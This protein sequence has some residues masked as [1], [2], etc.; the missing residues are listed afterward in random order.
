MSHSQQLGTEMHYGSEL[1]D[2]LALI[3]HFPMSSEVSEQMSER[4]SAAERASKAS[5]VKQ[6]NEWAVCA[7]EQTDKRVAQNLHWGYWLFWTIVGWR[8]EAKE[9]A[10]EPEEE[11][12]EKEEEKE[13]EE[14][15]KVAKKRRRGKR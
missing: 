13:E 11:E 1:S 2:V 8:Q 5:S 3:I 10:E 4:M 15:A 6:A 9:E 14:E 7:C 12:N